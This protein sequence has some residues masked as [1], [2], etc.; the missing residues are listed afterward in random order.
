MANVR[1]GAIYNRHQQI[2][3]TI[4]DFTFSGC[5]WIYMT[6]ADRADTSWYGVHTIYQN[7]SNRLIVHC[8]N[9]VADGYANLWPDTP[10]PILSNPCAEDAWT[11][12][13]WSYDE[14]TGDG[15]IGQND[16]LS[17]SLT[18]TATATTSETGTPNQQYIGSS[19]NA[20]Q[21]SGKIS[22][23]KVWDGA[24]LSQAEFEQEMW[25]WEPRTNIDTLHSWVPFQGNY[26][27]MH[28]SHT[29]A[30]NSTMTYDYD[31]PPLISTVNQPIYILGAAAGAPTYVRNRLPA[32]IL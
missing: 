16:S 12:L 10:S 18:H 25:Y 6:S 31:S 7:N 28:G 21:L 17:N 2:G 29:W 19:F 24:V 5:C 23:V 3:G 8:K 22:N 14:S 13:T 1:T 32:G 11:F 20:S 30:E 26:V 4:P 27:E 15:F 9:N